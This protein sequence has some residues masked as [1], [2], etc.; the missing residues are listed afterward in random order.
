MQPEAE[1]TPAGLSRSE[2]RVSTAGQFTVIVSERLA[3]AKKALA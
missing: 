1:S 3:P 2:T